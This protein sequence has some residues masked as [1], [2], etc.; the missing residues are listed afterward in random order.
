MLSALLLLCGIASLLA[1]GAAMVRG[2]SAI[3]RGF[4]VSP[5]IVGL[6]V[7][8]FATSAPEL[9]VNLIGA[10]RG[11]TEL[12]FGNVVGSNLANLGLVL[13]ATALFAPI[14]IR[15]E[16]VR[17]E[18]PL[19][20]L[21]TTVLAVM[22]L[23]IPLRGQPPVLDRADGINLLLLFCIFIYMTVLDIIRQ[24]DSDAIFADI[25]H[26]SSV[27]EG[28]VKPREWLLVIGGMSLLFLGGQ[29][30]ITHGA[31]LAGRLGLSPAVVGMVVV[32]VGTS[33]PEL[34]TSMIAARR[35]ETDLAV[36]N[37]V[38]SNLFNCLFVLPLSAVVRPLE[39]PAGGVVDLVA[40][41]L[42]AVILVPIFL[43]RNA[44]I[45]KP[46]GSLLVL[47][48]LGYVTWRTVTA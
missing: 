37:L 48:Y 42:F 31:A 29:L 32:A 38:G 2:A 10:W 7:V 28:D 17:R 1:G 13:G 21:A 22:C 14:M 9:V 41:W 6:T 8:A 20:L 15:G 44:R 19:L 46:V 27:P 45:G 23:D 34:V 16:I 39:I 35:Q 11:E 26:S 24:R 40:T 3:A 4:G 5:M 30:T 18:L 25:A 33:L 12:A 36:G 47:A 43:V